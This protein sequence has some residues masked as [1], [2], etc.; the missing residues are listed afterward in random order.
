MVKVERKKRHLSPTTRFIS[1]EPGQEG[2]LTDDGFRL[3]KDL[4]EFI[5]LIEIED[6]EITA[7]K[8]SVESLEAISAVLG[9]VIINGDLVVNGTITTGKVALN[10]ISEITVGVQAGSGAPNGSPLIT[11]AVP[12]TSVSTT[13]VILTFTAV[14]GLPSVNSSNFG[15]YDL[16][17]ARNGTVIATSGAIYYDDNF[18]SNMAIQFVDPTPGTNPT[19]AILATTLAGPGT[20]SIYGG[21]LNGALFK[22]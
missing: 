11:I 13:G 6:G 7:D 1:Q 8:I 3:M 15:S 16:R 22:R 2:R 4:A 21:V 17:L 20:F 10:A 9:N 5:S 19:Y 12:V 14:Q 18:A